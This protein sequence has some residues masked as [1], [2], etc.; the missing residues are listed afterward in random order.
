MTTAKIT[1]VE[2]RLMTLELGK[3]LSPE[4]L[5]TQRTTFIMPCEQKVEQRNNGT[6][7]LRSVAN[8]DGSRGK[9]LP[10]DGLADVGGD[11]KVDAGSETITFLSSSRRMT[12]R[13]ATMSWM[14]R[15][16]QTPAPRSL[17]WPYKPVRMYT[18]T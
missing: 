11:E 4:S 16:R 18:V 8:V 6:F 9:G 12:M 2:N 5:L 17:G 7:K 3:P 14:I 13:A 10:D 15:R 1:T